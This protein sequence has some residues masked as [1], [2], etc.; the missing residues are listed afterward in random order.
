MIISTIKKLKTNERKGA[1]AIQLQPTAGTQD[2]SGS[3]PHGC[4][5]NDG[6]HQLL[7]TVGGRSTFYL[8]LFISSSTEAGVLAPSFVESGTK[9]ADLPSSNDFI[10]DN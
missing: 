7:T 1:A 10:A 2:E 6:F 8:P 5:Q 4:F 3:C 9:C